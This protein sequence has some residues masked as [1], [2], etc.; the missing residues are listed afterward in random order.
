MIP[1]LSGKEMHIVDTNYIKKMG[2]PSTVLMERAGVGVAF[3]VSNLKETEGINGDITVIAGRGNNA[4]DAFV[5]ARYLS[6]VKYSINILLTSDEKDLSKD[7]KVNLNLIK[8]RENINILKSNDNW[9]KILKNSTVVIDGLLGTGAKAGLTGTMADI[10][11]FLED[12]LIYVVSVDLPSGLD[13]TTGEIGNSCIRA[14]ATITLG[15]PKLGLFSPS[16]CD[17]VGNIYLHPLGYPIG[18]F[19]DTDVK[20]H[21]LE[22]RDV[23][24]N[25]PIRSEGANKGDFGKLLI[26]AGSRGLVGA[27]VMTSN[28]AL[29]SGAGLVKLTLPESIETQARCHLTEV[30]TVPLPDRDGM[31]FRGS[32]TKLKEFREWADSVVFGPGV[33]VSDGVADVLKEVLSWGKPMVIDADGINN[34]SKFGEIKL[35]EGSIITPHPGEMARL[36]KIPIDD[37]QKDRIKTAKMAVKVYDCLVILKGRNTVIAE[38]EKNGGNI[39]INPTGGPSLA[40]GGTGDVLTGFI[41][42]Y[43]AQNYGTVGS[44]INGVYL[45]GLCGDIISVERGE[46]LLSA[47][48]IIEVL[49]DAHDIVRSRYMWIDGLNNFVPFPIWGDARRYYE[50]IGEG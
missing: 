40:S 34:L 36:I 23:V 44:A 21:L 27:A 46:G 20:T 18:S 7:A 32:I 49:P 28:S 1:V 30:M 15:F 5:S 35:P 16:A 31:L 22:P 8:S 42:S 33:G 3:F 37:V 48:D 14:D 41:G 43:I 4:G 19:D 47:T 2:I 6:E 50:V 11:D 39:Y 25:T 29:K 24:E 17:F 12:S 10:A 9:K 26:I 45:H 38:P 13:A